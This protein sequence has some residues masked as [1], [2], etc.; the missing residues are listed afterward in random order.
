MTHLNNDLD[1]DN[2]HLSKINNDKN[3]DELLENIMEEYHMQDFII[4]QAGEE[5]LCTWSRNKN[6]A[7]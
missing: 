6:I 3:S 2:L 1:T 5:K 4:I 7:D